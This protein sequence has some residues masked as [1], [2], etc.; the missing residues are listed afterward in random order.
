MISRRAVFLDRDGVLNEAIVR[1]GRPYSPAGVADLRILPGV[2]EACA[3]LRQAGFLLIAVTN[4]PD[5]A[6]KKAAP[7]DVEAI[8]RVLAEDLALDD[9]RVCPHDD[10]DGCECRK[11]KPGLLLDAA[12]RWNVDLRTSVMV[13]DR[14]RD[15]EAGRAAGCRT[16]FVDHGYNEPRPENCD[17]VVN[18]LAEAIPMLLTPPRTSSTMSPP[19]PSELSVKIFAD[20]ADKARILELCQNPLVKGFTTNPTLMR[21]AGVTDYERFAKDI[22]QHV[23]DLP[24]SFEVF[25]DEFEDMKRQAHRIASWGRNVFV[26]IPVTNTKRRAASALIKELVQEGVRLNVTAILTIEQIDEVVDALMGT[27]HSYVSV[28]AGRIADTGRDPIPFMSHAVAACNQAG[29]ME[30]IWA[31]PREVL[32]IFQ[33]DQIG[34]HVIT[35]TPDILKKLTIIGKD[36]DEFSQETVQLFY[37]DGLAARFVL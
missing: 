9:V 16:V 7:K 29:G 25:S 2:H 32:N 8:N 31:S 12:K 27:Q 19:A 13:G 23:R 5:I 34:C 35:V 26:K 17:I 24:I 20:G 33:A 6:R 21:Q 4:Q 37:K 15:I 22:L 28:F 14:A 36:L 10:L 11:P 18:S 30:V 1:N 3:R